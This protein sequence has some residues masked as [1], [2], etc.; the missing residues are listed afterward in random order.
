MCSS[1]WLSSSTFPSL[2]SP[3]SPLSS[4]LGVATYLQQELK[5]CIDLLNIVVFTWIV[6]LREKKHHSR[7]QYYLLRLFGLSNL[8]RKIINPH[9]GNPLEIHRGDLWF[10]GPVLSLLRMQNPYSVRRMDI[11]RRST[12]NPSELCLS[13][14]QAKYGLCIKRWSSSL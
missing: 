3:T 5:P 1:F 2:P 4:S 10:S 12:A 6:K 7:C 14:N 9:G 11:W 8:G 13:G